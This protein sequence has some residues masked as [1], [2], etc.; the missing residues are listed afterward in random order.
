MRLMDDYVRERDNTLSKA[1]WEVALNQK[2]VIADRRRQ[3]EAYT[4]GLILMNNA[5]KAIRSSRLK[6]LFRNDDIMYEE[7]LTLRGLTF[8]KER[9]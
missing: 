9:I 5:A 3:Q 6:D 1:R 7:E 8:R 2:D 4:E